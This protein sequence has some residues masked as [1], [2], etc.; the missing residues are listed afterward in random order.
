[1]VAIIENVERPFAETVGQILQP[2]GFEILTFEP[3][4]KLH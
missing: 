4:A 2:I 3:L 1:L